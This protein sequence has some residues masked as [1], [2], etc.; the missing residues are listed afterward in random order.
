MTVSAFDLYLL[1]VLG[2]LSKAATVASVLIGVLIAAIGLFYFLD[3]GGDFELSDRATV[4]LRR[5]VLLFVAL[6]TLALL[7]PSKKELIAIFAIPHVINNEKVQ[8][9][10]DVFLD[11][12]I[13]E[14]SVEEK[15]E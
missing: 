10:P 6:G 12:V 2:D 8:Q 5:L 3:T 15:K 11:Y 13:K 14:F 4:Q 1:S 9:L 7:T